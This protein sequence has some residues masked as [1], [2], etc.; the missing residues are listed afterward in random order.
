MGNLSADGTEPDR[1]RGGAQNR[2]PRKVD[3]QHRRFFPISGGKRAE[4]CRF[5]DDL[6]LNKNNQ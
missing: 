4:N 5:R 6:F 1:T 2:G 3:F